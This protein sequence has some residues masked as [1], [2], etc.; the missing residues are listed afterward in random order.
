MG[1]KLGRPRAGK[2]LLI[3]EQILATA[4]QIIDGEGIQAM[5]MRRLA[6]ELG[7]DPMA[8]YHHL[9]NKEAVLVGVT[10]LVFSELRLP[11]QAEA[12]WQ[13]Q[14]YAFARAYRELVLAHPNLVLHLISVGTGSPALLAANE[15]L[16]AA[17]ARTGMPPRRIVQAADLV[18]DYLNGWALAVG[19]SQNSKLG[20]AQG[21]ATLL[22][23][24]PPEHYPTLSRIFSNLGEDEHPG[25]IEEGLA[26]LLAGIAWI[27]QGGDGSLAH[28]Q[29]G[30]ARGESNVPTGGRGDMS[31]G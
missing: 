25:S 11:A 15:V 2:E 30:L 20:A 16:Y 7:V 3:R 1:R 27:A 12:P 31:F 14:V 24:Y 26:F 13:Q 17:L 8:I 5:S 19:L 4:L 18:V 21:L 6:A 10:E 28:Q 22:Q 23:Q 29:G 9:P